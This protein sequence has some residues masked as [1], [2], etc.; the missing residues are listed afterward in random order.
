VECSVS[1]PLAYEDAPPLSH[2]APLSCSSVSTPL[3]YED[4]PPLSHAA[5]LSCFTPS[6]TEASLLL[7]TRSWKCPYGSTSPA[8]GLPATST[9]LMHTLRRLNSLRGVE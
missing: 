2:A 4:A 1:T 3:A 5:P 7:H 8:V 9:Q 6:L